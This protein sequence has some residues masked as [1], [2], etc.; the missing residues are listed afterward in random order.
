[1]VTPERRAA[2]V[3]SLLKSQHSLDGKKVAVLGEQVTLQRVHKVIEPGLKAL[4]LKLGS[5]A[6]LS[7]SGTDTTSAQSQLDSFIERWKSEDVNAL[8]MV[9]DQVS[10][11]QFIQKVRAAI[12]NIQLVGDTDAFGGYAQDENVAGVKPNPYEG[13]LTAEELIGDK[14]DQT[15]NWK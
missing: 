6:I 4:G 8:F 13:A 10:H 3:L 12:P 11:T 9:G 14:Q 5:T 1:E 2:I 15:A 7:I